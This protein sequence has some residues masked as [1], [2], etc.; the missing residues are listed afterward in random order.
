ME[1]GILNSLDAIWVGTA[2]RPVPID[3][4]SK[5]KFILVD[6]AVGKARRIY[7]C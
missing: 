2:G 5:D 1:I 7:K 4:R 6:K 3:F